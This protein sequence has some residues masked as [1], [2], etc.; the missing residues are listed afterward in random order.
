MHWRR[1]RP[2]L[3]LALVEIDMKH[4]ED[5]SEHRR[6]QPIAQPPHPCHHPLDHPL[7]VRRAHNADKRR[8]RR[9]RDRTHRGQHSRRPHHPRRR[10]EA[11]PQQLQHLE[12]QSQHYRVFA[13]EVF[14]Q[15][16]KTQLREDGQEAHEADEDGHHGGAPAHDQLQVDE[17]ATV[18]TGFGEVGEENGDA[19]EE[20]C[21][22]LA[23]VTEGG[24]GIG[25]LPT[26]RGDAHFFREAL[27]DC[28]QDEEDVEDGNGCGEGH[29]ERHGPSGRKHLFCLT[30]GFTKNPSN[31]V[32]VIQLIT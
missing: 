7:P 29:H 27:G 10:A 21:G 18:L 25:L 9:I 11:V 6:P 30:S 5:E 28:D 15:S 4:V 24:E 23:D 17:N 20:D 3:V 19:E 8:N 16:T 13:A 1:M 2:F 26:D 31:G 32:G 22:V 14:H 12:E